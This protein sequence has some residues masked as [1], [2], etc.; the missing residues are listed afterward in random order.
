MSRARSRSR[1]PST[2]APLNSSPIVV[3][4]PRSGAKSPLIVDV[5]ATPRARSRSRGRVE[6]A[7]D[8]PGLSGGRGMFKRLIVACDGT[9]LNSDDGTKNGTL[10]IPSNITRISRA[11]KAVSQDGIQ[12]I[13]NYQQGLGTEGGK[14]SRLVGGSTGKGLAEDVREAYSFL[15]NNYHPGDEIFLL[16]FSRGAFTARS[17]GGLIGEI[18]LLTKKGLNTLPEVYEDVQNRRNEDYRPKHEDIPFPRKPSAGDPRYAEELERRGLTRLDIPIK[19]IAVWDTVGSLGIPRIGILQRAGLQSKQSRATTFY[20][21]KLSNC[22]ENAFQ[23]LALDET[24]SSFAPAIWEKPEGNRTT[25]RQV[26]FP[27]A[28]ANV[29]GGY[30]DMQIANISLAWMMS[31]LEPFLDMRGEYLFE[32]DDLN[33]KYYKKEEG[34]IRPWSFGKI[35]SELK[36][37]FAL[38]GSS[39]R[40][41]GQYTAVDPYTGRATDRPLRQTNEYIHP[42]VRTRFRLEGPGVQDRGLYEARALTDSYK[43]VVD[44]GSNNS[45]AGDAEVF[46]KIKWRDANAVK[47]LPEAPLWRLERELARRDPATYDYVKKPPATSSTKS[48]RRAPRPMSAD[49]SN[50]KVGGLGSP[51]SP[52]KSRRETFS[53]RSTFPVDDKPPARRSSTKMDRAR[54]RSRARSV[55]FASDRE[56]DIRESMPHRREKDKAWWEGKR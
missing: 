48:K 38:G 7:V 20:D 24:R 27:G 32:Q 49:F 42:S 23:A 25:L 19:C 14:I 26:W 39:Q 33:E 40:K 3:D 5:P 55:E 17:I 51:V 22:V 35:Y 36:G 28:H 2:R 50:S 44:Y 15:A 54:S 18:G 46:W 16:G 9:W 31:Q 56:T 6:P 12:Q 13:V 52:R 1:A 37:A 10:S 47:V 43:L 29:G 21:T 45:R 4:I 53:P 34:A 30:D 41:P 8:A 11:I